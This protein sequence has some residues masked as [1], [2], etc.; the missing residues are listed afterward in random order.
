MDLKQLSKGIR[1]FQFK[2][3]SSE[4]FIQ[5]QFI[6]FSGLFWPLVLP[7]T[8]RGGGEKQLASALQDRRE[9]LECT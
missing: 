1:L 3:A 4:L 6:S 7:L 5:L 8:V 2:T 9:S